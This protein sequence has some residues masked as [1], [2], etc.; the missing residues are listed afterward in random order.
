[1]T[2]KANCPDIDLHGRMNAGGRY[3]VTRKG[4]TAAE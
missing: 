3:P 1:M 4:G 2:A